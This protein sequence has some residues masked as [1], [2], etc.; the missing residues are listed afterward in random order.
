MSIHPYNIPVECLLSMTLLSGRLVSQFRWYIAAVGLGIAAVACYLCNM[1]AV[2]GIGPPPGALPISD[3]V[4]VFHKNVES[5][6][7]PLTL[8][9]QSAAL[10]IR[11]AFGVIPGGDG[12]LIQG[13]YKIAASTPQD[14]YVDGNGNLQR[15]VNGTSDYW[16]VGGL[17]GAVPA[18]G[19]VSVG[20]RQG[21]TLGHI[22]AQPKLFFSLTY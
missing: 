12:Q 11:L 15:F 9:P 8:T 21:L 3:P 7:G 22:S 10:R 14:T 6:A 1:H 19:R 13:R 2:A 16:A 17:G 18:L 20:A 4:S 5:H